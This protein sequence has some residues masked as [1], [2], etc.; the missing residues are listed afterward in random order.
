[1]NE[2]CDLCKR[3]KW[4]G[5]HGLN[6]KECAAESPGG[7]WKEVCQLWQKLNAV[8]E[9]LNAARTCL[10]TEAGFTEFLSKFGPD[11]E[12]P[13]SEDLDRVE[14]GME[15]QNALAGTREALDAAWAHV[16]SDPF[17][18]LVEEKRTEELKRTADEKVTVHLLRAGLPVCDFSREVPSHWPS[19]HAWAPSVAELKT[20]KPP[21]VPCGAC[22]RAE[23][24]S[25]QRPR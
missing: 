24:R 12:K 15:M 10:P 13:T 20:L 19:D 25:K 9:E 22:L 16:Q 21:Q 18:T 5:G 17:K 7:P 4:D 11:G 6:E 2:I 14:L 8:R 3:P 1:M 23:E